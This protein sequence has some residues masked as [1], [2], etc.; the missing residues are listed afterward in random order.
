MYSMCAPWQQS[1][2]TLSPRGCSCGRLSRPCPVSEVA[3]KKKS[4]HWKCN[5][6]TVH[7][8]FVFSLEEQ[9]GAPKNPL[10]IIHNVN[11]NPE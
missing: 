3:R 9:H 1:G 4:S 11:V 2:H 10:I 6:Q 8:V 5:E 7:S